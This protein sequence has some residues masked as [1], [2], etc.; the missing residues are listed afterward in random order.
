M[1]SWR[2]R[3]LAHPGEVAPALTHFCRA[4]VTSRI[5]HGRCRRRLRGTRRWWEGKV[6]RGDGMWGAKR[7]IRRCWR[8]TCG[9]GSDARCAQV[10]GRSG[11]SF[12]WSAKTWRGFRL[13]GLSG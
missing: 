7:R 4:L 2:L 10:L 6:P 5:Q 3:P 9:K 12:G 13:G 8:P 1:L 11:G